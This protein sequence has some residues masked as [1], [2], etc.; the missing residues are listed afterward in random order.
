MVPLTAGRSRH[1]AR[2][3]STDKTWQS[4]S[5]GRPLDFKFPQPAHSVV[6]RVRDSSS[7]EK[8]LRRARLM[9]RRLRDPESLDG[10]YQ[11]A[12]DRRATASIPPSP[13]CGGI[14][15]KH[16]ANAKSNRGPRL[17]EAYAV[18]LDQERKAWHAVQRMPRCDPR[19]ATALSEWQAAADLIGQLAAKL[20]RPEA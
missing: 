17:V 3:A 5:A 18:A 20:V 19:Y 4:D 1:R 2:Q 11:L 6:G 8:N 10:D 13:S 14:P 15:V 7:V 12:S 9:G 16:E